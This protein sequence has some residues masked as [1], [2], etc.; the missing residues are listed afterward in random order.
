MDECTEMTSGQ[1]RP[2]YGD[3]SLGKRGVLGREYSSIDKAAGKG[4]EE[5]ITVWEQGVKGPAGRRAT[6]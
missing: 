5:G 1:G 4:G 3:S 2:D 6:M